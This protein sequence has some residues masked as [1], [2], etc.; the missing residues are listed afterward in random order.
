MPKRKANAKW[1][2]TIKEGSGTVALGSGAFEGPYSFKSRFE[3]GDQ[4]GTNPEELIGAAHAGCF[5]M[6]LSGI[7]TEAGTPPDSLEVEAVVEVRAS[8]GDI[9]IPTIR[10]TL[11]GKVP[12]IDEAA[13]QE[14]A[15]AAKEGCPVSKALAGV[16]EITLDAKLTS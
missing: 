8:G 2:G 11:E 3:E 9:S 1:T 14:A 6:A 5:A 15:N 13:F 7:L 4:P 12:G 10:L 16:G